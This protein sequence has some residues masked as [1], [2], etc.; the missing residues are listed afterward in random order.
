[1]SAP[2]I[3]SKD[4]YEEALPADSDELQLVKVHCP[5]RDTAVDKKPY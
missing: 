1:M 5:L 4:V 2:S 3:K